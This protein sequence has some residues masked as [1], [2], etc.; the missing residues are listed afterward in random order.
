LIH[1]ITAVTFQK[2]FQLKHAR[3]RSLLVRNFT[4]TVIFA[5]MFLASSLLFSV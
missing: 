3:G 1:A 5:R 4:T 2:F